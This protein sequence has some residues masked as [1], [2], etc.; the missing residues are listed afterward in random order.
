MPSTKPVGERGH[1][2]ARVDPLPEDAEQE[3]G[4]D[5]RRDVR[6]HALQILVELAGDQL[7]QRNP[8]QPEHDHDDGR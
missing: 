1:R 6:L 5:R 8:Q 4:G 7:H 3:H 2:A